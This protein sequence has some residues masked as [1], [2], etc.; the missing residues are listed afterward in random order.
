VAL[1]GKDSFTGG[2]ILNA[3][4][5]ILSDT[6]GNNGAIYSLGSAPLTLNGGIIAIDH[7]LGVGIIENHVT[8][9]NDST[10]DVIRNQVN[11]YGAITTT[12]GYH[13]LTKTGSGTL[14]LNSA[15][16]QL[17]SI[18]VQGGYVG[19]DGGIVGG[20]NWGGANVVV[21]VAAGAGVMTYKDSVVANPIV[22][23]G[24]DGPT[25]LGALFNQGAGSPQFTGAITLNG[26]TGVGTAN[27]SV[28]ISGN[29]SGIG[30]LTVL[31]GNTLTLSGSNS[32]RGTTTVSG[33]TLMLANSAALAGSTLVYNNLG[34]VVSFGAPVIASLGGLA[35]GHRV[36]FGARKIRH[37]PDQRRPPRWVIVE[38]A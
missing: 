29:I 27:G 13:Q 31:G 34:G 19:A 38:R 15:N 3:G 16:P 9:A 10:I 12:D 5:L 6:S 30:G 14:Y 18:R 24:G 11:V 22:F 20:S 4:T 37:G 26:T 1:S 35:G 8:L 33:G 25:G 23:G 36:P 17:G 32:Y 2:L 7:T 28:V 21:T